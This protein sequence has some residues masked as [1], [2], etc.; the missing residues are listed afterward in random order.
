MDKGVHAPGVCG[1]RTPVAGEPSRA[2]AGA[3]LERTFVSMGRNKLVNHM[4]ATVLMLLAMVTIAAVA[5]HGWQMHQSSIASQRQSLQ[6]MAAMGAAQLSGAAQDRAVNRTPRKM[7]IQQFAQWSPL[8]RRQPRVLAVFLRDT[9]GQ[10]L[11]RTP[12]DAKPPS[13]LASLSVSTS[14]FVICRTR[15]LDGVRSSAMLVSHPISIADEGTLLGDVVLL[16][17]RPSLIAAWAVWC[18]AFGLPL[19]GVASLGFVVGLRW[20]RRQLHQP[21]ADLVRRFDEDESD[22]LA[23]LPIDRSDEFGKIARIAE[24]MLVEM[25]QL[26]EEVDDLHKTVDTRVADQTRAINQQL[27]S[28]QRQV[29]QDSLTGLGNRRLLD[30]RLEQVFEAQKKAGGELVAIMFDIDHFKA[31]N[32]TMGHAAGDELLCFFGQLLNGSLRDTDLV[33]RYAGDEFLVLLLQVSEKDAVHLAE[34]ILRLFAQQTSLLKTLPQPTLS[35]GVAA[36]DGCRATS[37]Q[38]LLQAADAA[39]YGAKR[40]G[41]DSVSVACPGTLLP[42]AVRV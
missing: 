15:L 25:R 4:A 17:E 1:L 7:L 42:S 8:A 37:G 30:E 5:L 12:L 29:W 21:L 24:S 26:R 32:D 34:R 10:L 40:K 38:H 13:A 39:L 2:G 9:E 18:L 6:T 23:R 3:R 35:A 20:I 33:F 22:W 11:T 28:A 31:H 36:L 41:K 27:K 19:T 16:A 14:S